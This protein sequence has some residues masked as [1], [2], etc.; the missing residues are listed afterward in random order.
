M[1]VE[2]INSNFVGDSRVVT[3]GA[4]SKGWE[5]VAMDFPKRHEVTVAVAGVFGDGGACT[6]EGSH[7]QD[8]WVP[9]KDPEGRSITLTSKGAARVSGTP[10]FIRP[11]CPSGDDKTSLV[12]TLFIRKVR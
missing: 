2:L 6:F 3:W 4:M 1:Q 8:A 9:L 10:N 7:D 12:A 5:G 11:V